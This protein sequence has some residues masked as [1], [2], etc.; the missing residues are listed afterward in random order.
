MITDILHVVQTTSPATSGELV[1][2]YVGVE[3]GV[4]Y[5]Q[6]YVDDHLHEGNST[7]RRHQELPGGLNL[8]ALLTGADLIVVAMPAARV[9][10]LPETRSL[11]MPLGLRF[12]VDLKRSPGPSPRERKR[13]RQRVRRYGYD[14]ELSREPADFTWF[15][16]NL[17]V[18]TMN[19]RH[20][21]RQRSLPE[22]DARTT[23][24]NNGFLFFVMADGARVAGVLCAL[25]HAR[26]SC[27]ARLVG[28]LNADPTHHEREALKTANHFLLDWARE[29]GLSYVDFQGC[30]PFVA[31]GTYQS[32]RHLGGQALLPRP[33]RDGLR[34]WV[35]VARDRPEIRDF[36]VAHPPVRLDGQGALRATY[37]QDTQRPARWDLGHACEGIEGADLVDLDVFLRFG[38]DTPQT[39]H[40]YL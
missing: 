21:E 31:K 3:D 29:A 12:V 39:G 37:F 27:D 35:H 18:P 19:A 6:P 25:D 20:G 15:Y 11:I 28:W 40:R 23:I 13:Q 36:L 32:K 30:E 10:G 8:P 2:R 1:S 5:V 14:F 38:R 17:H 34:L 24:F 7:T 22:E 4:R 9:S 33:P 16:H 26:N